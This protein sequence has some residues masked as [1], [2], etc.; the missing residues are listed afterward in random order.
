MPNH[1]DDA[2][3]PPCHVAINAAYFTW[4]YYVCNLHAPVLHTRWNLAAQ[5]LI[6]VDLDG[7]NAVKESRLAEGTCWY[8]AIKRPHSVLPSISLHTAFFY[9]LFTAQ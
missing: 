2:T 7:V 8:P 5:D 4:S 9:S 1:Q 3:I 6:K